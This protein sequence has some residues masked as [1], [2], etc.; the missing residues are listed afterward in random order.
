MKKTAFLMIPI[1]ALL[2]SG[3][4]GSTGS[5]Y[6]GGGWGYAQFSGN[7]PMPQNRE[8]APGLRLSI[9]PC[10]AIHI[11]VEGILDYVQ[12]DSM[13]SPEE[14]TCDTMAPLSPWIRLDFSY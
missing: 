4:I 7:A 9:S 5:L 13:L 8:D 10:S 2:L 6:M 12:G 3:C 14:R 11:D 1:L